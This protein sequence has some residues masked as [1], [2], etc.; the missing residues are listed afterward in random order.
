MGPCRER[1]PGCGGDTNGVVFIFRGAI[2]GNRLV[3][4]FQGETPMKL[5]FAR[6]VLEEPGLTWKKEMS[7]AGGPRGL[8]ETY[9]LMPSG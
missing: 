9:L 4:E 8:I 1:E 6:E 5:R 3:M 2:E 7:V